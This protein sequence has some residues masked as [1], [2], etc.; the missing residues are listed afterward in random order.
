MEEEKKA[1]KKVKKEKKPADPAKRKKK[2]R[3]II[4]SVT[5]VFILYVIISNVVAENTPMKTINTSG[6][7]TSNEEKTYLSNVNVKIGSVNVAAGD[8]VKKGDVLISYDESDLSKA[9]ELAQLDKQA[10][11]GSYRNSVQTNNEKLGDLNEANVNMEVL[12]QQIAD[13]EAYI[14]GLNNKIQ[15][16]KDELALFGT[17]L[18]ISLMDWQDQPD[19]AEYMNLQKMVQENNYEQSH[20][21]E[22][23]GW[24]SELEVYNDMLSKYKEYRSEMK[25][26]KMH[27]LSAALRITFLG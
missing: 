1:E 19:Y 12:D 2:R 3:I 22:I 10:A 8:A 27:I 23:E 5:G 21:K 14:K 26:Q 9:T 6:N 15:K 17:Q 7:V 16:K 11:E 4:L 24:E 18:Q 20:N 25:S 13:T